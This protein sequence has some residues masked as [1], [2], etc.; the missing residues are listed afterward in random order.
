MV[1]MQRPRSGSRFSLNPLTA[2][3]L[4]ATPPL[5]YK[6][7]PTLI[8]SNSTSNSHRL[9]R[10]KNY[11]SAYKS[12]SIKDWNAYI[13]F[14]IQ[15]FDSPTK[16]FAQCD[17]ETLDEKYLRLARYYRLHLESNAQ[18][19]RHLMIQ[20][21]TVEKARRYGRVCVSTFSRSHRT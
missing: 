15:Q 13:A 3:V 11:A 6:R 10:A 4:E 2:A 8:G 16:Y 19:E 12:I 17:V 18:V 1:E 21:P 7:P 5:G 20:I 9:L 14:G